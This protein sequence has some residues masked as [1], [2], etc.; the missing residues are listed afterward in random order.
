MCEN[1]R[2][3]VIND[4]DELQVKEFEICN[5]CEGAFTSNPLK[6]ECEPKE[7]GSKVITY[8]IEAS[9]SFYPYD[10]TEEEIN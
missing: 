6:T 7:K 5:K 2:S 8:K 4:I 9:P 10:K 1:V 3:Q